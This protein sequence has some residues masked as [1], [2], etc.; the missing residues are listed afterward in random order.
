M[1]KADGSIVLVVACADV[2]DVIKVEDERER[3]LAHQHFLVEASRTLADSIDYRATVER[4]A[5]LAVPMLADICVI[6]IRETDGSVWSFA[7]PAVQPN[8]TSARD[9]M[10]ARAME[11]RQP[12]VA[13]ESGSDTLVVP[14]VARGHVLGAV[15]LLA[16]AEANARAPT[17]RFDEA[18]IIVAEGLAQRA[19]IAIDN[20]RLFD[21]ANRRVRDEQALREAVAAVATKLTTR[22]ALQQIAESSTRSTEADGAFVTWVH[23]DTREVEVAAVAGAISTPVGKIASYDDSYTKRVTELDQPLIVDRLNELEGPLLGGELARRYPGWKTLILPLDPEHP[24]GALFL[25]RKPESPSF[26]DDETARAHSYAKLASLTFRKLRLLEES[27]RRREELVRVSESRARLTRGFSHDVKN[28]LGVADSHAQ[29]LL[30]GVF[31]AMTEQQQDSVRGI[32]KSIHASLRLI[33]DLLDLAR[34]EAGQIALDLQPVDVAAIAR[35]VAEDFRA[36]ATTA[37]LTLDVRVDAA[38]IAKTDAARV[39]QILGNLVSNAV[40]YTPEGSVTVSGEA[41]ARKP[42]PSE[43]EWVILRV[44]DTGPGVPKD[45]Q[46][47]IFQE[48]TRLESGEKSGAGVGLAISRRIASLLGGDIT[49]ESVDGHGA[50][51]TLWLPMP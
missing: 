4:V 42:N 10:L 28:P 8:E 24:S 37:G 7:S 9:A 32:R 47:R 27:E 18:N 22:E 38:M 51:F 48:F 49:V 21:E 40:K 35:E 12:Q 39:R 41:H 16:K 6:H 44:S 14:L 33:Q 26:A 46:E 11:T 29:L 45:Q 50:V 17:A 3:L 13:H 2:D 15:E 36:R 31:G 43:G 5:W 19:A 34:A 30:E 1:R 20:A 23:T 25:L